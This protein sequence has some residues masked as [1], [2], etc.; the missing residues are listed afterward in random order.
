MRSNCY[1]F[2]REAV[3]LLLAVALSAALMGW[4]VAT[5]LALC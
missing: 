2:R 5:L 4:L 1:R 3:G